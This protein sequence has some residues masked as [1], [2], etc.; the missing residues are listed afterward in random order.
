M[1]NIHTQKTDY[2]ICLSVCAVFA[3]LN[4]SFSGRERGRERQRDGEEKSEWEEYDG[5]ASPNLWGEASALDREQIS[6][7]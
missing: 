4:L 7:S 2:Y 6:S 5:G 1:Y 3:G